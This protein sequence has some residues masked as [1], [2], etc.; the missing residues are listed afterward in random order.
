MGG[1][2]GLGTSFEVDPLFLAAMRS[3]RPLFPRVNAISSSF[4]SKVLSGRVI[5]RIGAWTPKCLSGS[6]LASKMWTTW[7]L[8]VSYSSKWNLSIS[9][10]SD[11]R[12]EAIF[13][14][15]A[16]VASGRTRWSGSTIDG[17]S[18]WARKFGIDTLIRA[19]HGSPT[20]M[21]WPISWYISQISSK[22]KIKWTAHNWLSSLT[23]ISDLSK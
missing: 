15:G 22:S 5:T 14:L 1:T 12:E 3:L 23:K 8:W 7:A 17:K 16:V 19:S 21:A 13:S 6:S 10:L 9:F 18:F 20:L 11:K 2:W 4:S